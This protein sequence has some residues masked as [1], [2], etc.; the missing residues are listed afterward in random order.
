MLLGKRAQADPEIPNQVAVF[1][2]LAVP[3]SI[4]ALGVML[5]ILGNGVAGSGSGSLTAAIVNAAPSLGHVIAHEVYP[6]LI[7]QTSSPLTF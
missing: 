4:A 7:L 6:A 1:A 3:V 5:V 2:A